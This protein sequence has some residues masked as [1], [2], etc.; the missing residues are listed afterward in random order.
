M[1]RLGLGLACLLA[2]GLGGC[3]PRAGKPLPT[4]PSSLSLVAVGDILMHQDVQLAARLDPGGFPALWADLVPLFKGADFAFA[5]LESPVAPTMG[6]PGQPFQFN[7][8]DTLPAALRASGFTVLATANN[9]AF[10][11]GAKGVRETLERLRAQRLTA[12]GT[13]EDRGVAETLQIL[14]RQGLRVAFLGFTD[15]FNLDLNRRATEPWVRKLDLEPALQAVREARARADLVVVSV[16]WGN[17]YQHQPT[18]RQRDIASALVAGG[19]D[20]IL[21][22]HPHVLQPVEFMEAGGRRALVAFSLGNFISNQDRMYRADQFPVAG[23]D[24]RDGAALKV[25]FEQKVGADG[26][27]GLELA[28]A[29]VEPLWTENNW[30][31]PASRR[32]I[33]VIRVAA[34]E[35][36]VRAELDRL[37]DPKD[38]LKELPDEALRRNA[39]LEKQEYLRTLILRRRRVAEVVGEA[40]VSR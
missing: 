1:G 15:L 30:G 8:P 17:E 20:L 36:R 18:R 32:E 39:I 31:A 7:A 6:Q 26:R 24:N 5:N 11:Q 22:H 14:E 34:A 37:S 27:R 9:H 33:R 12:V 13:G 35:A 16:H 28:E 23:G 21:G 10:D 3:K 29:L 19:C 40:F 4:P 25:R 38:G 2:L